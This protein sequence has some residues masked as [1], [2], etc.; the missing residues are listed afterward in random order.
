MTLQKITK[1]T[2][3]SIFNKTF[4]NLEEKISEEINKIKITPKTKELVSLLKTYNVLVK[5]YSQYHND[6]R[7]YR[8]NYYLNN[9]IVTYTKRAKKQIGFRTGGTSEGKTKETNQ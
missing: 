5:M 3:D 7:K 2:Y 9:G 4:D 6:Y 1:R 8:I